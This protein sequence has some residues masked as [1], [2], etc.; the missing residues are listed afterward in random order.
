[1]QSK[2]HR[3]RDRE[4]RA[5]CWQADVA[6]GLCPTLSWHPDGSLL[7]VPCADGDVACLERLSWQP[8]FHL[9]GAHK[10]G[11][12][13]AC[14]CPNGEIPHHHPPSGRGPRGT[15]LSTDDVSA[16]RGCCLR[17]NELIISCQLLFADSHQQR[18]SA[19]DVVRFGHLVSSCKL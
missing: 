15:V 14:F 17:G 4:R 12:L 16:A 10:G 18:P 13:I 7:A 2:P 11:A 19:E 8:A 3:Q 6:A 1:M 5:P 9:A